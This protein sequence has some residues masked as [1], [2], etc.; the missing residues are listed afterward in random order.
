[1]SFARYVI[2]VGLL[3]VAFVAGAV[4]K[5]VL[6]RLKNG[7]PADHPSHQMRLDQFRQLQR[8]LRIVMVGDSHIQ[9]GEWS[10]WLGEV[11]ANRGVG[12]N[13][14][15]DVMKRLDHIPRSEIAVVLL[16]SN[17]LERGASPEAT[18]DLTSTILSRLDRRIILLSVP[19]RANGDPSAT[20]ELNRLNKA[21]CAPPACTYVDL[22]PELT[23][24][25]TLDP[26]L[27]LDGVHLTG[28]GY[29]RIVAAIKPAL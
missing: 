22:S 4:A 25:G 28:E 2:V 20:I 10:E 14:A 16:G 17:D 6:L 23:K 9:N 12:Q 18:A 3:A 11:V 7:R 26:A 1:M 8:S 24:N 5:P 29:R 21:A 27:T 13:T 15:A 19:P